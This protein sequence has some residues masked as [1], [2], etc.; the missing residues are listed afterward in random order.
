MVNATLDLRLDLPSQTVTV[1]G[2]ADVKLY[3]LM[4][5]KTSQVRCP[6][7]LPPDVFAVSVLSRPLLIQ[8]AIYLHL[9]KLISGAI[10]VGPVCGGRAGRRRVFVSVFVGLLPR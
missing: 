8:F 7:A 10:V 4:T 5:C 2:L 9:A 1:L 3:C 6:K